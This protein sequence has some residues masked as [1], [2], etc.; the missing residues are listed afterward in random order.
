MKQY[1]SIAGHFGELQGVIHECEISE[2]RRNVLVMAHG[3]RGS[4]EGGGRAAQL[5]EEISETICTVVRF[6]FTWCTMLS[7]QVAELK[8]VLDFVR[9]T[10]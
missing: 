1:F 2:R 6:N 4:M 9:Q 5:A 3:F 10:L 7:N 8:G